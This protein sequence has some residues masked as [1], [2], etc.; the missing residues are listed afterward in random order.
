LKIS[1]AVTKYNS[2]DTVTE[3]DQAVNYPVE[4]LYS[5]E[6][7]GMPPHIFTLKV[8]PP[9]LLRNLNTPVVQRNQTFREN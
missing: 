3:E 5:L 2:F 4:F 9:I 8:G 1:G 6:L 7:A